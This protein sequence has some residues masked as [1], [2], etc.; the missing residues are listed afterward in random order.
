MKVSIIIVNFNSGEYLKKCIDSIYQSS[1]SGGNFEII[2]VDNNSQDTSLASIQNTKKNNL[3]VLRNFGNI[4][5]AKANNLGIKKSKGEYILLLNPDTLLQN[6]TLEKILDYMETDKN[7]AVAT[8][9]LELPNG[10]IDDACHRGFPTPF[11]SLFYFMGLSELFPHSTFFNG[12][13][14][15]YQNM[16]KTHVI[17]SCVGAFMMIRKNVGDELKWLDE[18]YFW[19]GEDV[20]FC[21]RIKQKGY[22]V[23]YLPG[24]KVT[25]FKGI[26]SG[27]KNHSKELSTA[28]EE[29]RKLAT[30]ARF[31]VMKLFYKK[32]YLN[33][34]PKIIT[35]LVFLGINLKEKLSS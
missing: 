27:I 23:I 21:Y 28:S 16:D 33:K 9:R 32:H 19:Y 3:M 24:T 10:A 25:H 8:P 29:T 1:L 17:D 14:L 12:Y 35:D 20:D 26:S 34:Y 5:F 6:D 31:E 13:H 15:G 2:I 22:K 7:V 18:D 4:G 30:K 11:N